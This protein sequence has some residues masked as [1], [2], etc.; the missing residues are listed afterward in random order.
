MNTVRA[1]ASDGQSLRLFD[2]RLTRFE[3]GA[4]IV[5]VIGFIVATGWSYPGAAPLA[6]FA[7]AALVRIAHVAMLRL[8]RRASS[9][10]HRC[11]RSRLL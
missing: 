2:G 3:A 10:L 1:E 7:A 6:G 8:A 4:F 9:Q 5:G 11:A